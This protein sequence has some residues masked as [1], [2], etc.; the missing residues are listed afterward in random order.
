MKHKL[1]L[2]C[3]IAI[4]ASMISGCSSYV[5]TPKHTKESVSYSTFTRHVTVV[6][7]T[8]QSPD[9][10]LITQ[11]GDNKTFTTFPQGQKLDPRTNDGMNGKLEQPSR[12]E[13][14]YT[15]KAGTV[16]VRLN[17][18]YCPEFTHTRILTLHNN[19]AP[20]NAVAESDQN[21]ID[22]IDGTYLIAFHGGIAEVDTMLT[23]KGQ[24]DVKGDKAQYLISEE[25]KFIP[26][27]ETVLLSFNEK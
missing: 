26:A 27:L 14:Y 9:F 12:Y 10:T 8:L 4:L 23:T 5:F 7:D 20:L 3:I 15:N 2:L 1:S 24:S 21:I 18:I 17:L 22:W 25:L 13:L 6:Q 11:E 19:G 16:L